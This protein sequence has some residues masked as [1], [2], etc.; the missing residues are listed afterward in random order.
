MIHL[1]AWNFPQ[2][3]HKFL[4]KLKQTNTLQAAL[5]TLSRVVVYFDQLLMSTDV[6][7]FQVADAPTY[8][9][10]LR[11]RI[12]MFIRSQDFR[13]NGNPP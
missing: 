2:S 5:Q 9:Y 8:G 13:T 1:C 7:V 3:T 11:R 12:A 6:G 10:V 4:K